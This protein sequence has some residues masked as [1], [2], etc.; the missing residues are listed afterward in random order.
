[1]FQKACLLGFVAM[2]WNRKPGDISRLS[3]NVMTALDSKQIP[4]MSF[5]DLRELLARD[6]SHTAISSTRPCSVA[7][8]CETST[9]KQPSTAS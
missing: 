9:D 1:M 7:G 3:I 2:N 4:A 8:M 6:R 5:D